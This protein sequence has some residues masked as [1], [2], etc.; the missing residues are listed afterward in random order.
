MTISSPL[1]DRLGLWSELI[2]QPQGDIQEEVKFLKNRILAQT[3]EEPSAPGRS[4]AAHLAIY[5]KNIAALKALL[6]EGV[7]LSR[8]NQDGRTAE[9]YLTTFG[10][11]ADQDRFCPQEYGEIL[12][13]PRVPNRGGRAQL[14]KFMARYVQEVAATP[15]YPPYTDDFGLIIKKLFSN[16]QASTSFGVSLKKVCAHLGISLEL[17]D[18]DYYPRDHF[19]SMPNGTFKTS[20]KHARIKEFVQKAYCKSRTFEQDGDS[21][22]P[23]RLLSVTIGKVG[24]LDTTEQGRARSVPVPTA[25]PISFYGEGGNQFVMT[26][27]QGERCLLIGRIQK[28]ITRLLLRADT[29]FKK[30]AERERLPAPELS[31][32]YRVLH[33]MFAQGLLKINEKEGLCDEQTYNR[34][35]LKIWTQ[36]LEKWPDATPLSLAQLIK[37]KKPFPQGELKLGAYDAAVRYLKQSRLVR[38]IIADDYH[39]AEN[40][41][42]FLPNICYHLDCFLMPG[43]GHSVFLAD[44]ELARKLLEFLKAQAF[45]WDLSERDIHMLEIYIST[46]ES[47]Y[48]KMNPLIAKIKARLD[49]LHIGYIPTPGLFFY[50][51]RELYDFASKAPMQLPLTFFNA[52]TGFSTQTRRFFYLCE[53]QRVGD[54]LG[55]LLMDA[56]TLFLKRVVADIDVFFI[57]NHQDQGP[58]LYNHLGDVYALAQGGLHC[59]T[60]PTETASPTPNSAPINN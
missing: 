60:L 3:L 48:V 4:T 33:K 50:E 5:S 10:Q 38:R 57:G 27:R 42:A 35:L 58:R 25:G 28:D 47:F 34:L 37:A 20:L 17:A 49:Q 22:H 51:S 12:A 21:C 1:S 16:G 43:P 55:E 44:F 11:K 54:H 8:K 36:R 56:F 2:M 46:A 23:C 7:W 32:L 19:F 26:N 24:H 52:V 45:L 31:R 9:A 13:Q 53:R 6:N 29:D 15:N 41:V 40:R 39:I 30:R 59:L 18:E 14:K